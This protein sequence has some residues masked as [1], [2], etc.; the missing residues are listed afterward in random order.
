MSLWSLR[1]DNPP[2]DGRPVAGWRLVWSHLSPDSCPTVCTCHAS[3][4][5]PCH[6]TNDLASYGSLVLELF[7]SVL[8][9]G[10]EKTQRV[11]TFIKVRQ[12]LDFRRIYKFV[13]ICQIGFKSKINRVPTVTDCGALWYFYILPVWLS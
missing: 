12:Y 5:I 11:R 13:E 8:E 9:R 7:T 10:N 3:S 6:D 2:C 4:L 1:T